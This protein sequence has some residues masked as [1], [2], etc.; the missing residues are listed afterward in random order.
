MT[1]QGQRASLRRRPGGVQLRGG[2]PPLT[3]PRR[4]GW[5]SQRLMLSYQ[6]CTVT[7]HCKMHST[8]KYM[9]FSHMHTFAI[10]CFRGS[11]K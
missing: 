2:C 4:D 8:T 7:Q 11:L 3:S 1:T 9:H 5:W 10:L 6:L